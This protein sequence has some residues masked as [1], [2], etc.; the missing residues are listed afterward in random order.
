MKL[1]TI[2][3][4]RESFAKGVAART[5][6]SVLLA[7]TVLTQGSLFRCGTGPRA[8][9]TEETL[10][11]SNAGQLV[12]QEAGEELRQD[13]QRVV[14]ALMKLAE[15]KRAEADIEFNMRSFVVNELGKAD[16]ST[17]VASLKASL[18]RLQKA[19]LHVVALDFDGYYSLVSN[20][21]FAKGECIVNISKKAYELMGQSQLASLN[22]ETRLA[23]KDGIESWLY[24]FIRGNACLCTFQQE[25]MQEICGLTSYE[26][27][28]FARLLRKTL[29]GLQAQE[30]IRGFTLV[31]GTLKIKR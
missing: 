4:A 15:G 25:R 23:M 17:S 24:T 22:K 27:K 21:T 9:Y 14:L 30:I 8:V 5:H 3:E 13:D 20:V 2:A 7:P 19:R 31:G 1:S 26:S 29:T 16:S 28:E 18:I 11:E 6:S 10:L 12:Y